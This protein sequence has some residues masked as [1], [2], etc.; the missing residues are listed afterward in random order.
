MVNAIYS[1]KVSPEVGDCQER[2]SRVY[3]DLVWVGGLLAFWIRSR[4]WN[5]VSDRLIGTSN[6]WGILMDSIDI[7]F[8]ATAW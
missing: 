2:A 5:C 7:N 8:V 4:C 3:E 6:K 1:Y